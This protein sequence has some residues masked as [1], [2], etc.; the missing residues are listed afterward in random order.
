MLPKFATKT[1]NIINN[2]TNKLVNIHSL[3]LVF[4]IRSIASVLEVTDKRLSKK[5]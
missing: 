1:I 5:I 2:V 4:P 3:V